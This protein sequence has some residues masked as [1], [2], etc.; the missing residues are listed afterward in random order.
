[1]VVVDTNV[2]AYLLIQGDQTFLARRLLVEDDE[3]H[4][5]PFLLVEFSNV[6][7]S[8]VRSRGLTPK[9]AEALLKEADTFLRSGWHHLAHVAALKLASEFSVSA[10]D[11]RFL[12][13]ARQLG[14]R[15]VTEDR[16]LRAAAPELTQSLAEAVQAASIRSR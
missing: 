14:Q 16:R 2:L 9:Q 3:W 13:V 8:Y 6:L 12:G 10:Y 5:E 4:S 15:L 11:A 7:A 1:M